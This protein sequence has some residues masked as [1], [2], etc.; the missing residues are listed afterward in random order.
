MYRVSKKKTMPLLISIYFY[1][2]TSTGIYLTYI[3][4]EINILQE[5]AIETNPTPTV[6][7]WLPFSMETNMLIFMI[8]S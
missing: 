2:T 6:L 5:S 7:P 8:L 3:I 1:I 4:K